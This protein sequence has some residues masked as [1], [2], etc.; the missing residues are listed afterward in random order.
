MASPRNERDQIAMELSGDLGAGA[1]VRVELAK[2]PSPL[3]T[4]HLAVTSKGLC[5]LDLD[6]ETRLRARVEHSHPGARIEEGDGARPAALRLAAY[7]DGDLH[8]LEGLGTDLVGTAFQKE[9]WAALQRIGPGQ[10]K[11]YSELAASIGRPAAVRAVGGANARNP[12]ALVVPCHRVIAADGTLGG[13]S[14]G[15]RRKAWLLRHEGALA[16]RQLELI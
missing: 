7:F 10:T 5:A 1:S 9:V 6:S 11:S 12:V 8:A 4:I 16:G 2:L 15:L 14:G 13:Y 3:G